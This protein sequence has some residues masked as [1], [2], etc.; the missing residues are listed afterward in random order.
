MKR[1]ILTESQLENLQNYLIV[2]AD[3][4][5]GIDALNEFVKQ[6]KQTF[7]NTITKHRVGDFI[8]F[9]FWLENNED[10]DAEVTSQSVSTFQIMEIDG[11]NLKLKF[12]TDFRQN[13]INNNLNSGDVV[14][15]YPSG[16][17]GIHFRNQTANL[18]VIPVDE[19][20]N[21]GKPIVVGNFKF[22]K[23]TDSGTKTNA[24]EVAK[25][26]MDEWR[27]EIKKFNDSMTYKPGFLGMDNFFFFP[28]GYLAMDKILHKFGLNVDDN[29]KDKIKFKVLESD[30]IGGSEKLNKNAIYGA[31]LSRDKKSFTRYG[32]YVDFV[33]FIEGQNIGTGGNFT[34]PVS[35]KEEGSLIKPITQGDGKAKINIIK[36]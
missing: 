17:S 21:L 15:L 26:G 4:N 18:G 8:S 20:G 35:Y 7:I 36:F 13:N 3:K 30:I 2:E 6:I 10:P 16:V 29:I 22:F 24:V 31:T 19:E 12:V 34:V 33:F 14:M 28:S 5:D 25:E 9:V 11:S 23:I 27:T 32:E 1:L